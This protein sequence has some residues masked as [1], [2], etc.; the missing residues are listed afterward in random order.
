MRIVK[1]LQDRKESR[2]YAMARAN[3]WRKLSAIEDRETAQ[4][5]RELASDISVIIVCRLD[6]E[7]YGTHN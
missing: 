1:A 6:Q 3:R 2:A 4:Q 5:L 7:A